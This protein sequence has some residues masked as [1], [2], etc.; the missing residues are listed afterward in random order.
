M[1]SVLRELWAKM[2]VALSEGDSSRRIRVR[3]LR[4]VVRAD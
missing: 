2:V 4:V 3:S 1:R